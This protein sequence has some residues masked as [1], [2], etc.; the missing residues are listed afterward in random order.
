MRSTFWPNRT[1][2]VIFIQHPDGEKSCKFDSND[3]LWQELIEFYTI[4]E[5]TEEQLEE[6]KNCRRDQ[7]Q[8]ILNRYI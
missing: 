7:V 5:L 3:S 2:E 1:M 4:K 6:I 8:F